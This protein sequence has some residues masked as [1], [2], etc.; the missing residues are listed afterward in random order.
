MINLQGVGQVETVK[1]SE[2]IVGDI[3]MFNFGITNV[4][5]F[6]GKET[7]KFIEIGFFNPESKS[8]TVGKYK[9]DKE[10]CRLERS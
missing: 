10:M 3:V 8:V 5:H 6:F 7:T 2:L 9:K 1:A 4:V